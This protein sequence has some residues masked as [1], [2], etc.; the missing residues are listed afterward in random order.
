VPNRFAR[1][2]QI[3]IQLLRSA[4]YVFY[5]HEQF[6]HKVE[7]LGFRLLISTGSDRYRLYKANVYRRTYL[8]AGCL[9]ESLANADS[10]HR[11]REPR[12]VQ[13]VDA[14]IRDGLRQFLKVSIPLQP[15]GYA[16]AMDYLSLRHPTE[17]T[18]TAY[19]R[20]SWIA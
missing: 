15:A 18:S 5:L 2:P 3:R 4:F 10:Y 20:K 17:L 19:N 9:E 11:L 12:Y 6:H 7:S 13:R 16:Q 14:P 8:T 1:L